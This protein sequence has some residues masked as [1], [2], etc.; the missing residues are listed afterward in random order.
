MIQQRIEYGIAAKKKRV[1][2]MKVFE[3]I[4][5]SGKVE[6]PKDFEKKLGF[7]INPSAPSKNGCSEA[8]SRCE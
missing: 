7:S 4:Q 8:D 1:E 2:V 3:K 5:T 6:V